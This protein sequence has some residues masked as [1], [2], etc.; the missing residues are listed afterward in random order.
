MILRLPG[1]WI[2][3]EKDFIVWTDLLKLPNV[4]YIGFISYDEF[5]QIVINWD[6]GLVAAKPDHEYANYL[7]NNKQYQYLALGKPFVSFRYGTE[8]GVFEDLVYLAVD[9]SDYVEKIRI[10]VNKTKEKNVINRGI[11]IASEQSAGR[12]A[13]QFLEIAENLY[14]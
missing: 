12:R 2:L 11:K 7:N 14:R 9:K 10:A 6:I 1:S 13:K 8:Y 4:R 5:P 3:D